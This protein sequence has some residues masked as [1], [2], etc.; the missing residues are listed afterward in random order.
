MAADLATGGFVADG[1][2]AVRSA[3]EENFAERGEVGAAVAARLHGEPVVDLWGG[4]ADQASGRPWD[5]DTLCLFF[6]ATKGLSATCVHMLVER[7]EVDLDAPVA[8]YWPEF[9]AG[10]KESI[11]VEWLLSHR[12]GLARIDGDLTYEQS[13]AWDPV[14]D[15]LAAQEPNWE[16][17]SAH[18]YHMRSFGWL[19]GE[20]VRRVDGR[21]I[22]HFMRDEI[23]EPL[24]L[25]LW[26]GLP[27]ELEDRV[28]TLIP[29]DKGFEELIDS[30][31]DDMLLG[32]VTTGPSGHFHYDEMWN[33]RAV[34]ACELPSSNGIG[35][36]RSLAKFYSA[37]MGDIDGAHL[38]GA[39]A[40]TRAATV[41]SEGP[42]RVVMVDTRFGLGFMLG[43]SIG[44]S[45]PPSAFGHPGAG[46]SLAFADPHS[47]LSF[48]YVMNDLRFDLSG[49]PR[50]DSLLAALY[51]ALGS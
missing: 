18:G 16:P 27:A 40:V 37:L 34:H 21:T 41:R 51:T 31:P 10:G 4:M 32:A 33:T 43:N 6:S 12:A 25:D 22:G 28:A 23:A 19:V 46:G 29:P 45:C 42:D 2:E 26:I 7:G 9:G 47:G 17:D 20:L 5:E 44:A 13:L 14:I 11:T 36:A 50:S 1:F 39:D 30:L 35:T 15:A 49:D 48:A 24:G 3:F 38:L 8:R